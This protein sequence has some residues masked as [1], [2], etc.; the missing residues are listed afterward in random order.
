MS[1]SVETSCC[2]KPMVALGMVDVMDMNVD[3]VQRWLCLECGRGIDLVDYVLDEEDLKNQ[4][5]V[6][7]QAEQS[8]SPRVL[9][10]GRTR[11]KP[12]SVFVR[13]GLQKQGSAGLSQRLS[14][15]GT[16]LRRVAQRPGTERS[17]CKATFLI[18]AERRW[19]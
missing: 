4:L 13:R 9:R 16:G 1:I 7:G 15:G 10:G 11:S 12:G 19:P 18:R 6:Y 14:V 17:V 2:G 8:A 5:E 3:S